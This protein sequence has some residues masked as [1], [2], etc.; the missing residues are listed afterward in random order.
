METVHAHNRL[1]TST[2]LYDDHEVTMEK[3]EEER[4]GGGG[5]G[6]GAA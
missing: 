6:G 1:P 2:F 4:R 5:E 3:G